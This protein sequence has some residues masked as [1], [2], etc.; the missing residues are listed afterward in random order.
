MDN[1]NVDKIRTQKQKKFLIGFCYFGII[2]LCLFL[3]G[4]YIVPVLL[5]LILAYIIACI[6]NKPVKHISNKFQVSRTV[7]SIIMVTILFIV[8]GSLASWLGVQIFAGIKHIFS[9]L[10]TI[11]DN[12]I[13]PF[14]KQAFEELET[15]FHYANPLLLELF[16][17]NF[18]LI[19][20]ALDYGIVSLSN[21]ILTMLTGIATSIPAIFVKTI[22][23]IIAT[24][25]I[26]I[27]FEN[28][29][30]FLLRQFPQNKRIILDEARAFLGGALIRYIASYTLIFGI[31]FL[32]LWAGL[33]I[34]KIPYA[35]IIALLIAILDILPI[36]GTG[37][38]LI[39]WGIIAAINGNFK[40]AVS[41]ILLYIMITIIRN[42]IEPKLVGKQ[43]GL[44]PVITLASMLLGLNFFGLL[45]LLALPILLAF[46]KKL[47]DKKIIHLIR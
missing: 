31:T 36:L 40:M 18:S 3:C 20:Q 33:V 12:T 10:P 6:L 41:I 39:P 47:N 46:L 21:G 27:D 2:I 4:R 9:F 25:F 16:E 15:F 35:M 26:T 13:I 8:F 1:Q 11:F 32:E 5:P 22:I 29:K 24:I 23:T 42:I 44:H 7:V 43:M 14:L 28:I 37:S 17:N 45:G 19:L 30:N 38:V 34:I